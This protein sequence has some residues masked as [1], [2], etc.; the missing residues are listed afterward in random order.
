[1]VENDLD[2]ILEVDFMINSG[3]LSPANPTFSYYNSNYN[4]SENE[5]MRISLRP[6]RFVMDDN[7]VFIKG[8]ET[9]YLSK[10]S[11]NILRVNYSRSNLIFKEK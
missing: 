9:A 10:H 7:S 6:E 5:L 8:T 3:A 1:M 4:L 11:I 2:K